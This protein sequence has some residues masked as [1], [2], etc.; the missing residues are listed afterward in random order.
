LSVSCWSASRVYVSLSSVRPFR[1]R[2]FAVSCSSVSFSCA[3]FRC[4][5][6]V[7]FFRT[8]VSV[9]FVFVRCFWYIY[10]IDIKIVISRGRIIIIL[11]SF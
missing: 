5:P 2:C 11:I 10:E 4:F 8:V 3:C 7:R 6:F 9:C 1:F